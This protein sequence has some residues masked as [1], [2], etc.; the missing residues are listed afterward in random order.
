[1]LIGAGFMGLTILQ[2][3]S[4]RGPRRVV[5]LD[6]RAEALERATALG[7]TD[8]VDVTAGDAAATVAE[9]TAGRGADVTIEA[10]GAQPALE[11]AG[12][13]TRMSGT[14]AIAGYHQG[15]PREIP[16]GHWNWMAF[17]IANAH[18]REPAT[19]LEGL[20]TGMRLLASGQ[21]TFEGL[22]TH[23]FALDDIDEA[24]RTAIDKPAGFV[25]ATVI[26]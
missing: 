11:L 18:F 21:V 20:R 7:A 14:V 5:V 24:F 25:K 4:L 10:T 22:V 6:T 23:R 3:L 26:P 13:T 2:V 1:V 8:T 12:E 19:I 15:A 9:R 16:L 17:T